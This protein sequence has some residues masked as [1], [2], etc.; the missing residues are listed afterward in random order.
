MVY[1]LVNTNEND[2]MKQIRDKLD[3]SISKRL[4]SDRPIGCLL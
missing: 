1:N 4:L 2:I 3:E